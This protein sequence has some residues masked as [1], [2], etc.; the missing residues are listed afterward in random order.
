[1]TTWNLVYQVLLIFALQLYSVPFLKCLFS[2]A[3][4][5]HRYVQEARF[6]RESLVP[7]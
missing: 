4:A 2:L 5:K 1:M 7:S 6:N 3:Y